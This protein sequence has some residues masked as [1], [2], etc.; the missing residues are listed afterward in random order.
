MDIEGNYEVLNINAISVADECSLTENNSDE[1]QKVTRK[2]KCNQSNS[3]RI[4][5]K[6]CNTG[7]KYINSSGKII[8]A[9]TMDPGCLETCRLRCDQKISMKDR[10]QIFTE[11]WKID[12]HIRQW[13]F[14]NKHMELLKPKQCSLDALNHNRKYSRHYYLPVGTEMINVCKSM[15]LDTLSVP[16]PTFDTAISKY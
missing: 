11:F 3:K 12:D 1:G 15:F 5:R 7:Q 16:N 6:L 4:I 9:R 10:E 8:P 14:I 13:D 2:S